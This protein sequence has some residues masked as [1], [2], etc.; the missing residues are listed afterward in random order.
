MTKYGF[1]EVPLSQ[2]AHLIMDG[3]SSDPLGRWPAEKGFLAFGINLKAA[4]ALGK[5]FGQNAIV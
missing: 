2:H 1:L 5:Q 4:E 3:I